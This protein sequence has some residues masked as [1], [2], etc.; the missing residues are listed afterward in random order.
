[1]IPAL[2]RCFFPHI[3]LTPNLRGLLDSTYLC[4][5]EMGRLEEIWWWKCD[6]MTRVCVT[7][8]HIAAP[9]KDR[10]GFSLTR[11]VTQQ[12]KELLKWCFVQEVRSLWKSSS[13]SAATTTKLCINKFASSPYKLDTWGWKSMKSSKVFIVQGEVSRR[14]L[15]KLRFKSILCCNFNLTQVHIEKF[16]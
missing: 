15:L 2:Q 12:G 11:T 1:M 5:G 10:Y 9:S 13:Q 3:F 7:N 16:P 8:I 6:N 4:A 14:V